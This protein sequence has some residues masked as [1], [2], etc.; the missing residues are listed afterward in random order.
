MRRRLANKTALVTGS[1]SNIGRVL[2]VAF[3][4]EGAH[5][6]VKSAFFLTRVNVLTSAGAAAVHR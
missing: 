6:I 1:T 4:G 5:V 3:G 2:A